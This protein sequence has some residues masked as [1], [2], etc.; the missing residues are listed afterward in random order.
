MMH[1][2]PAGPAGKPAE[3]IGPPKDLKKMP[4]GGG[5]GKPKEVRIDSPIQD[6]KPAASEKA[7]GKETKNPFE[8]DRRDDSRVERAADYSQVTGQLYFVHAD[9][10]L[11]VLRYAPL[12]KEDPHGGSF[13]LARDRRMDSY[14]EGDLVSVRGEIIGPKGSAFLGGPLYRVQ[15]IQ[16]LDRLPR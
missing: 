16:L 13:V 12:G 8:P 9:G 10:G 1:V 5:E 6:V 4:V 15:S 14:R 3:P 2:A 7:I 11:W